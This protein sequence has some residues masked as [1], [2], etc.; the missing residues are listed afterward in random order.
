MTD[1]TAK[2][3][4]LLKGFAQVSKDRDVTALSLDARQVEHGGVFFALQ[5]LNAHGLEYCQQAIERQVGV[6]I[7]EQNDKAESLLPKN[8]DTVDFIP[9]KNLSQ[10][11]S[12]IAARFYQHPSQAMH[13]IAI[14]GTNGKTTCAYLVAQLLESQKKKVAVIGTLGAGDVGHLKAFD[15]TTPD[16]VSLQAYLAYFRDN[17][18]KY[19]VME[20]SSHALAQYRLDAVAVDVAAFTN[21]SQDHLDYHSTMQA[22]FQAKLRLFNF[23][24]LQSVVIDTSEKKATD[25]LKSIPAKVKVCAYRSRH[26][27]NDLCDLFGRYCLALLNHKVSFNGVALKLTYQDEEFDLNSPLLGEFNIANLLLSLQVMVALGFEMLKVLQIVNKLMPPAGRLQRVVADNVPVVIVDY[28]HTPDALKRAL[29]TLKAIASSRLVLVFGCGGDRDKSK[30][31]IMAKI[32]E[33][34]ADRVILTDDNPRREKSEQIIDDVLAGYSEP[35]NVTV[36]PA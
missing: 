7:Y 24:D 31:P 15:L 19:V 28:A 36:I 4:L 29:E 18:Y 34:L 11:V 1:Y 25:I 16:A 20:A 32:S 6:V 3:S 17:D 8:L 22:Y 35:N 21:L 10:H 14:T 12:E 2:L 30:R 23:D 33:A 5:G 26:E 9:V 27:N 13:V